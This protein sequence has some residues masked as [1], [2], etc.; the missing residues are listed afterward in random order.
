MLKKWAEMV[1]GLKIIVVID[2]NENVTL[3]SCERVT[4]LLM[5]REQ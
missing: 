2:L 1:A 5:V 4:G 3:L